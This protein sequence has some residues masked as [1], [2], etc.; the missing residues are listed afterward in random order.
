M[1]RRSAARSGGLWM[2]RIGCARMSLL[3]PLSAGVESS[4]PAW[5][6]TLLEPDLVVRGGVTR[7]Q[8]GHGG[9]SRARAER[10]GGQDARSRASAPDHE[11]RL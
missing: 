11:I 8:R 10:G 2:R 1:G 6:T 4:Q 9:P 7:A 3:L 5:G